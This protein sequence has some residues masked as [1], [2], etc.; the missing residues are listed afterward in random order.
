M[1]VTIHYRI[2]VT[3]RTGIG[4]TIINESDPALAVQRALSV[5]EEHDIA[6]ENALVELPDM[7]VA[8]IEKWRYQYAPPHIRP[9]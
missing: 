4:A 2:A 3:E 6:P 7:T 9:N 5:M 1:S 8:E